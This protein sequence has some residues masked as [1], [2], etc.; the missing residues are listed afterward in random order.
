MVAFSEKS[1]KN[2]LTRTPST[3]IDIGPDSIISLEA[4]TGTTWEFHS[5]RLGGGGS[6]VGFLFVTTVPAVPDNGF[7]CFG[8]PVLNFEIKLPSCRDVG[9]MGS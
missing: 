3:T 6:L 5:C 1:P 8:L 7:A 2:V 9:P 4:C